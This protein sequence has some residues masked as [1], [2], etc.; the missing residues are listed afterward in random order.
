MRR[1]LLVQVML[2]VHALGDRLD[3]Q[4]ALL[5][6][7]DIVFVVGCLDQAG[8]VLEAQ[9]RGRQLLQV[10][11]GAQRNAVLRAFFCGK[12]EQHHGHARIDQV[13]GDLRPHDA[14]TQHGDFLD[15]EI[16]HARSWI[17]ER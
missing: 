15:D 14:G 1:D 9:R 6:Q 2:P 12:V 11:D 8:L 5:E 10:V 3:H 13:G 17:S 7:G 4:V 16:G